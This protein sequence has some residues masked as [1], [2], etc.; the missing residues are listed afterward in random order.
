MVF[1]SAVA[2]KVDIDLAADDSKGQQWLGA[3][4]PDVLAAFRYAKDARR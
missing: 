3:Q 2:A 1:V 4:S